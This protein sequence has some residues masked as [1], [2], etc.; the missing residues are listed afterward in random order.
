MSI[1]NSYAIQ[2]YDPAFEI[3]TDDNEITL[4]GKLVDTEEEVSIVFN[5]GEN[6][7]D[8]LVDKLGNLLRNTVEPSTL[9]LFGLMSIIGR[10]SSIRDARSMINQLDGRTLHLDFSNTDTQNILRHEA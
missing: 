1:K 5:Y 9:L 10:S 6:G 8:G 2:F 4:V 3:N 7:Y